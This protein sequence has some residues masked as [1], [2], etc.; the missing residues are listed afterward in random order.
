[1]STV[2]EMSQPHERL[3]RAGL[4]L[5]NRRP[6]DEVVMM[7]LGAIGWLER[8][9]REHGADVRR[10]VMA[11]RDHAVEAAMWTSGGT[12]RE[13][14]ASALL[15]AMQALD[16]VRERAR[17]HL[18][19]RTW[20]QRLTVWQMIGGSSARTHL[21]D[22]LL[23]TVGD[24]TAPVLDQVAEIVHWDDDEPLPAAVE[25]VAMPLELV[26]RNAR[27]TTVVSAP[28]FRAIEQSVRWVTG[29]TGLTGVVGGR[30]FRVLGPF[31]YGERAVRFHWLHDEVLV[32][33]GT[34][35]LQ[36]AAQTL[37]QPMP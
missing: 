29:P 35:R 14:A 13:H 33:F 19:S 37:A 11:A 30:P 25:A 34:L 2:A 7:L 18:P 4:A 17:P 24:A 5:A 10:A 27:E 16:P 28:A 9:S 22:R 31:V 3:L 1:M 15:L 12:E 6:R 23:E 21:L 32:P 36:A 26:I 8:L 20:N